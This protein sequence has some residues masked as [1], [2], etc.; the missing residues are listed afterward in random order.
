MML[1][2]ALS[3]FFS[4]AETA[5]F[6]LTAEQQRRFREHGGTGRLLALLQANPVGLL[7]AILFG[8]LVVNILFFCTG[9][10]ASVRW[11]EQQGEWFEALGGALVLL[12][13]ITFGEILPKAV[14]ITHPR[15]VL[16]LAAEP[17]RFWF[18]VTQPFRRLVRLLLGI[19]HLTGAPPPAEAGLTP[20]E[21]R[22]LL[23]AVEHEP[24]FG[25]HEK[26]ILEDI[27]N[28]SDVRVREIMVPRVHVMRKPVDAD[29]REPLGEAR[30]N[31]FSRVLIYQGEDDNPVGY[32]SVHELFMDDGRTPGL[33]PFLHPLMFVPETK[34]ADALLREL[35][36]HDGG[37]ISVVDEYGGLAGIVTMEDLL[38]EVVTDLDSGQPEEVQWI[39]EATC[40]LNGQLPIR[41]WRELLAGF[42]PGQEVETIA[43]DT[44]GG[45]IISR[46]G[47][48]P[49]PG[50]T[51]RMRNLRLTVESVHRRRIGTVLLHL[52]APEEFP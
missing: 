30:R 10:T 34:R 18:H 45:L 42:L 24:G 22:E 16:L 19:L 33:E 17:L 43:F 48:M 1:L 8:N 50:D 25:T 9:A 26:E 47:R 40:R 32:V 31:E 4:G 36:V 29:R 12:A 6:S 39:D 28:L 23:A 7:T 46:L 2:L 38:S 41:A 15:G 14:G 52:Q 20:G 44:L 21:L 27:V 13:L 35:M 3:A 37:M 5:L 51:V 11:G 49:H